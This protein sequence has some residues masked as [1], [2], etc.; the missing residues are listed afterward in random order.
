VTQQQIVSGLRN[1]LGFNASQKDV[2][3]FLNIFD[4]TGTGTLKYT[5]F[6]DA[7]LPLDNDNAAVL[8]GK[9]PIHNEDAVDWA[10]VLPD[11]VK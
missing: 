7:F 11:D 1:V 4:K 10:Q 9:P 8:A 6:C 5:E 2:N 3:S